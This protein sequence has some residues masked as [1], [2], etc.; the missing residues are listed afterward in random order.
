MREEFVCGECGSALSPV[1]Y[2]ILSKDKTARR[3]G[4]WVKTAKLY[5]TE[6]TARAAMKVAGFRDA[7]VHPVYLNA[8]DCC[9]F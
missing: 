8:G 1:G 7:K 3:T 2:V 4:S 6:S 5:K 9:E